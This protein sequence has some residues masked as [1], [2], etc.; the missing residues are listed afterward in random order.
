[1]VELCVKVVQLWCEVT[2]ILPEGRQQFWIW[3]LNSTDSKIFDLLCALTLTI[4]LTLTLLNKPKIRGKEKT[5]VVYHSCASILVNNHEYVGVSLGP[6]SHQQAT[7]QQ[8]LSYRRGTARRA[9]PLETLSTT[10]VRYP[11]YYQLFPENKEVTW[12][13]TYPIGGSLSCVR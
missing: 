6:P 12:P 9:M 10:L 5:G 2:H 8:K 4:T 1:M 7:Q 3:I 11:G 13:W